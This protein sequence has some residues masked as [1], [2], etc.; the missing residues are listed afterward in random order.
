MSRSVWKATIPGRDPSAR[1]ALSVPTHP[2]LNSDNTPG[3]SEGAFRLWH[4]QGAVAGFALMTALALR[5]PLFAGAGFLLILLGCVIRAS[6]AALESCEGWFDRDG[7]RKRWRARF[8]LGLFALVVY[9]T[10]A[11]IAIASA[12]LAMAIA[13]VMLLGV[14]GFP[15]QG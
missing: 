9:P 3:R 5:W 2:N 11:W 13:T 10:L 6:L 12:F 4:L 15:V 8:L 7:G 14:L 1:L